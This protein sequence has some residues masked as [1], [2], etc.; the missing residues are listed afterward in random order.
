M[1]TLYFSDTVTII[2]TL[3]LLGLLIFI[4]IV[5]LNQKRIKSWKK[6]TLVLFFLGLFLCIFVVMRD[7]YVSAMQGG[8]GVFALNSPQIQLAYLC[9]LFIGLFFII[10]IFV[11]KQSIQKNIFFLFSLILL[12]KTILIEL[13]RILL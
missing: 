5:L 9:A 13:S 2:S 8:V 7:D 1:F 3:F 10:I 4:S 11:K 6:I 12:F